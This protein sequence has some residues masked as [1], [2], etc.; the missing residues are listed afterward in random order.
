MSYAAFKM[1]H[2]PTGIENCASGFITHAPADAVASPVLPPLQPDDLDPESA[3]KRRIGPIPNLV[4]TAANVI[5]VYAVRVQEDDA[6]VAP[7][8]GEP[9][10][11]G[12]VM[13]GLCAARLELVCHYR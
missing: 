8:A 3:P 7:V 4:V 1:M 12:G 11:G 10:S 6:R 13:D 5:E 9:R 2:W